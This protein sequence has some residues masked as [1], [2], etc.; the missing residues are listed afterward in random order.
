[1]IVVVALLGYVVGTVLAVFLDRLYTGAPWRGPVLP[2][3]ECAVPAPAVARLGLPGYLLLRGRR[4]CGARLPARLVYLPLLGA[5][6]FGYAA[7]RVDG[8]R[9]ALVLLFAPALLAMTATDFE[10]RLLPNR[11][12]YPTLI[13]ALALSWA[14]PGR[15]TEQTLLGGA[16]GFGAMLLLY[17]VLPGFGFGDVKL[18]GLLGL[19]AGVTYVVPGLALG[20]VTAGIASTLLLATRRVN[21]RTTI[22]YGPYL[23]FAAFAF[24]L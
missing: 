13:T 7:S 5:V 16:I 17:L 9:L 1:M 14:W 11:I 21:L 19:L 12:M 20:C 8:T 22:A 2:C 15:G 10:R 18:A 23:A 24:M 6:A 4:P 3:A